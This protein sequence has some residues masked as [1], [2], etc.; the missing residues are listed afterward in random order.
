MASD[1][2]RPGRCGA[3]LKR[4]GF[5]EHRPIQG[6]TRCRRHTSARG[7]SEKPKQAAG[8]FSGRYRWFREHGR[9]RLAEIQDSRDLLDPARS[10]ALAELAIDQFV[11][12]PTPEEVDELALRLA[13]QDGR[14]QVDAGDRAQARGLLAREAR[15]LV[16]LLGKR[17]DAAL[18]HK[19]LQQASI[20][21][22]QPVLERAGREILAI[23]AVYVS[24]DK[25]EEAE[26]DLRR[27]LRV[28]Y[29]EGVATLEAAEAK[30]K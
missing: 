18:R 3:E 28:A 23:L 19:R 5:C 7:I 30:F 21:Y 6:Q 2:P 24:P 16:D 20:H 8:K 1:Q 17:Q 15:Q 26:E 14:Q 11:A 4:G 25:L 9:E 12:I 27:R 29:G 22:L 10:V 13:R